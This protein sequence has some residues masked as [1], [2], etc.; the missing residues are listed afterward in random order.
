MGGFKSLGQV[1]SGETRRGDIDT[2]NSKINFV[3]PS[4]KYLREDPATEII[5]VKNPGILEHNLDVFSKDA[6]KKSFKIC[7]DGKK[8]SSGFGKKN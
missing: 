2:S 3:T 1:S 5:S 7:L 4:A 6:G 8:I